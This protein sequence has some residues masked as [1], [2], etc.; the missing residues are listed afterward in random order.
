MMFSLEK[1]L[2]IV[3]L[4]SYI[5]VLMGVNNNRSYK[6]SEAIIAFEMSMFDLNS[7]LNP[8]TNISN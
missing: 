4:I 1:G 3:D 8:E 5:F 7:H 6:N 2:Y